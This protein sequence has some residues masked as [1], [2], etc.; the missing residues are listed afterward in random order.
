MSNLLYTNTIALAL[1]SL[2]LPGFKVLQAIWS[3]CRKQAPDESISKYKYNK[4]KGSIF[5]RPML[6]LLTGGPYD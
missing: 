4:L 5:G 1:N 6:S 2:V 3:F